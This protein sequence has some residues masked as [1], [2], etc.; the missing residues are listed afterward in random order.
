MDLGR[1]F[2]LAHLVI[3]DV[4]L[5]ARLVLQVVRRV[6]SSGLETL[7]S[8]R[9]FLDGFL[10]DG[11][12]GRVGFDF[13]LFLFFVVGLFRLNTLQGRF[14]FGNLRRLTLQR[15]GLLTFASLFSLLTFIYWSKGRFPF[16]FRKIFHR[17]PGLFWRFLTSQVFRFNLTEN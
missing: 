16:H 15:R 3:D 17:S 1:G 6:V 12:F 10:I 13:G 5:L 11:G 7:L 14:V 2:A 4:M 9:A 8:E